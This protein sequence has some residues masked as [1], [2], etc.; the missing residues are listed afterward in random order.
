MVEQLTPADMLELD[1]KVRECVDSMIRGSAE[2]DL[3]KEIA[4]DVKEKFKMSSSDFGLLV[5]E[6]FNDSASNSIDRFQEITDLNDKLIEN[7]RRTK[8]QG[9]PTKT[10]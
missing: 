3:R 5:K 1:G 4:A 8:G 6:R 10:D 7:S 9:Q 2:G